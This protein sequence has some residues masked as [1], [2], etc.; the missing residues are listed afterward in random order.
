MQ[1][2]SE[3]IIC[4]HS[5]TKIKNKKIVSNGGRVLVLANID[6]SIKNCRDNIYSEIKK[7]SFE[8]SFYRKDIALR[9]LEND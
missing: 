2:A 8:K 4:F 6:D 9:A 7:I 5:G 3:N 1:S